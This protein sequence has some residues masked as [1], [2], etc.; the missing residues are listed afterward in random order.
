MKPNLLP[1]EAQVTAVLFP[2]VTMVAVLRH[3]LSIGPR[4]DFLAELVGVFRMVV[5]PMKRRLVGVFGALP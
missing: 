5:V 1:G 4:L 3:V 2:G